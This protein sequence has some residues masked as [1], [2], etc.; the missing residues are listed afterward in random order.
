MKPE[1]KKANDRFIKF[2]NDT[3]TKKQCKNRMEFAQRIGTT[4]S[5]ITHI[6]NYTQNIPYIQLF[7][8]RKAFN[9]SINYILFG[10]GP[11]Y[12]SEPVKNT[13]EDLLNRVTELERNRK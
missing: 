11:Q 13:L 7:E 2:M 4:P 6:A 5:T 8:L 9:V 1:Q 3:I 10:E 12:I